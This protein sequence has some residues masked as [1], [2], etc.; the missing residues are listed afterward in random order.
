MTPEQ[1]VIKFFV[2]EFARH[3]RELPFADAVQFLRGGLILIGD[4]VEA[5]KLREICIALTNVDAQLELIAGPQLRLPFD[6]PGKPQ[7]SE[8]GLA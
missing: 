2:G 4:H 7:A 5:Q 8:G 6:R 1:S 3:V